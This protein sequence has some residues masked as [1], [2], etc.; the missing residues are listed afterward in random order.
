MPARADGR[1]GEDGHEAAGGDVE[2]GVES[3]LETGGWWTHGLP[4]SAT[5]QQ[6]GPTGTLRRWRRFSSSSRRLLP[7]GTSLVP[8]EHGRLEQLLAVGRWGGRGRSVGRLWRS[9]PGRLD[10]QNLAVH[11]VE[12]AAVPGGF[13]SRAARGRL[14][15]AAAVEPLP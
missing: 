15:P 5:P 14:V 1:W 6:V 11:L 8:R 12:L 3:S 9:P 13:T 7:A 10:D 4:Q 2:L